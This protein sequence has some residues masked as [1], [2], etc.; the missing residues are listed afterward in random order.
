MKRFRYHHSARALCL[1]VA[2]MG[3]Y[4]VASAAP[5]PNDAVVIPRFFNDCVVTNLTVAEAYPASIVFTEDNMICAGGVNLHLWNLSED[6][7][8]TSAVFNNA[9]AFTF[10]ATLVLTSQG[11]GTEGGLRV[12][13]WWDQNANGYFN[14]RLPD[15]EIA[16]FGGVLPFYSFTAAFGLRYAAGESIVL[17]VRYQPVCNTAAN[18]G[19]IEYLVTYLGIN[20][21]SGPL[22]FNNCTPGEEIHGCYG[23]M[24][25]ARVGGRIQNNLFAGGGGDPAST[26]VGSFFDVFY[27]IDIADCPVQNQSSSWGR[28]KGIYR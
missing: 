22:P 12:S 16:C 27:D 3:L 1:A 6:G 23:I 25:N 2:G 15:G 9:D 17:G 13:P 24:D 5:N 10:G 14:V 19:T 7:G 11:V 8:A 20:Y 21:S 18:P 4:T 28:V 26:N